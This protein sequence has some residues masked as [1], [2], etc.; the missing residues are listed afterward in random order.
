MAEEEK[1]MTAF[2]VMSGA[3]DVYSRPVI[4]KIGLADVFDAIRL[5]MADF[6]EKPSHYV[7]LCLMYPIAGIFL[8]VATSS[9]NLLP[10]IFPL[11]A[12]FALIGPLAAIGLYEI[13]RRREAGM[14]SSWRHAM[15]V[16]RSP[17]FPSIVTGGLM[18][19]AFFVVWLVAAQTLYLNVLSDVFPRSMSAFFSEIFGTTEGMQLIIW[20]NLIG[21]G[22]ALIVLATTVVTFPIL[23]DRDIG[24]VAAMETSLRATFANPVPVL[25]W[26]LI[27]AVS[28]AVATIPLFVGLALVMPILGHSTW[29]LYRKLVAPPIV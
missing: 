24:L 11:I 25:C 23:L 28:L 7:F 26:G 12:G 20:G 6:R 2:H 21:F 1:A 19:F 4:N 5:G 15:E 10:M 22:F 9:A 14:D 18:L 17:A 3:D 27:V 16:T 29:H 13:S 8:A